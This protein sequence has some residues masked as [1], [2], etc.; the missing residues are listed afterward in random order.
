[1]HSEIL[2]R[3]ATVLHT[4]SGDIRPVRTGT[5]VSVVQIFSNH[6]RNVV[7]CKLSSACLP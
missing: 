7:C 4:S 6:H 1:M 3:I 2:V 5:A